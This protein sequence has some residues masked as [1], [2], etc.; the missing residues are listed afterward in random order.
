VEAGGFIFCS[1][2]IPLDPATGALV[3]GDITAQAER[4]LTNLEAVLEA[5]GSSLSRTVK[6]NV[7]LTRMGDFGPL[8]QVLSTKFPKDPPARAVVEVSALPKGAALEM[9]LI[10]LKA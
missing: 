1:G 6:L 8:N 5:A 10:A 7:Y 4:V 2:Q 9:D 3:P